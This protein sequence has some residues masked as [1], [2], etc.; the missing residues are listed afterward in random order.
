M[1]V[2]SMM[3]LDFDPANESA[4]PA[5]TEQTKA[6]YKDSFLGNKPGPPPFAGDDLMSDESGD[7]GDDDPECPTIRIK[8]STNARVQQRWSRAITFRV[9]GG[10]WTINDHYI[11]SEPWRLDFDPDFDVINKTAVWVRLPHLPLAY[12]D[13]EILM[14]IGSKLGRV[15]KIDYNTSNGFR[16]N[17]ARICVEIDLRKKPVSK[18]I[19]K[20]RVRCVEYEGLHTV[21]FE[22]GHYDHLAEK[23][24]TRNP[25]IN[26]ESRE[27]RAEGVTDNSNQT[28]RPEVLE[29]FGP[30]MLA[31]RPKRRKQQ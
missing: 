28:I 26:Q 11:V 18:Y 20:R 6:S 17:Y 2:A 31:T 5:E 22:C 13:E 10:P 21:C 3:N 23:W 29:E 14:D 19:F 24:P 8:K 7:E 15:E 16:G 1:T 30:W 4:I 12:F 27:K 25:V 9:L